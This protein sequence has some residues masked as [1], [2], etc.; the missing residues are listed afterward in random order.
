EATGR[1]EQ[2]ETIVAETEALIAGQQERL[3]PYLDKQ[4]AVAYFW[5]DQFF[6]NGEDAPIGRVL[7]DYGM[8][9]IS[10]GTAPAGEIDVLSLEQINMVDSADIIIAADFLP[11]QTAAQE[12]S[13]L[14]RALPAVQ[15]GGYVLLSPEMAQ[16][17]YLESALSMQWA[18]PRLVDAV[19]EGA[20]GRGKTLDE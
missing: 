5:F 7:A 20:E 8:D 14:Y 19:I 9:V 15:N 16:A 11:D 6:V 18:I 4:V 17:L 12:S 13:E 2:A 10:P 1:S 3:Q